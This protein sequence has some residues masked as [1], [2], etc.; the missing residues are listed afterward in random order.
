MSLQ[1]T[2]LEKIKKQAWLPFMGFVVLWPLA[3]G[4]FGL[5]RTLPES[6]LRLEV[7]SILKSNNEKR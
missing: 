5:Y 7:Q 2:I 1:Y 4:V 3:F 6:L